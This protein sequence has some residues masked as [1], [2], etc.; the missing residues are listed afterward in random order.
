[1]KSRV[2]RQALHSA[3]VDAA[4][5]QPQPHP[6]ALRRRAPRPLPARD[7]PAVSAERLAPRDAAA[8]R[9][10]PD[11]PPHCLAPRGGG[12]D[13]VAGL[14]HADVGDAA[15]VSRANDAGAARA[16]RVP[17]AGQQ[18]LGHGHGGGG[19]QALPDHGHA[20]LQG[21]ARAGLRWPKVVSQI[22][23]DGW[24]LCLRSTGRTLL[25]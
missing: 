14:P 5:Q 23:A 1:M 20:A 12:V 7:D 9:Q 17:R 8:A 22:E 16:V 4:A 13:R 18:L 19:G 15:E 10:A 24:L 25:I 21:R 2:P 11:H 6:T 3:F